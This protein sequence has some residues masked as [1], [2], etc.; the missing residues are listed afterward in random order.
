M[1]KPRCVNCGY[2]APT[3]TEKCPGCGENYLVEPGPQPYNPTP[4]TNKLIIF[5]LDGVLV[6]A[7][8]EG[9]FEAYKAMITFLHK[10]YRVFFRTLEE[11]LDW[12]TPDWEDTLKRMGVPEARKEEM[13]KI[14][15]AVENKH[16]YILPWVQ[17]LLVDLSEKYRLAICS[18]RHK[19]SVLK[20]FSNSMIKYFDVVVGAGT[21]KNL[22]PDPEGINYI[23]Q[24]TGVGIENTLMIGDMPDDI[25]AAIRAGVS[26]ANVIWEHGLGTDSDFEKH[27]DYLHCT[28]RSE[29]DFFNLE[30]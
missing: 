17:Y 3:I 24:E 9:L 16:S 8:R 4:S 18:N 2:E 29:D 7:S 5:D 6:H 15:Y 23:M 1:P 30:F 14:F 22:K 10:D 28:L 19:Y 25:E 20:F 26:V 27:A 13:N 12:W 21:V 11:F